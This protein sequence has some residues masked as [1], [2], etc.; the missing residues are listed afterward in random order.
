MILKQVIPIILTNSQ[1]SATPAPFQHMFTY[2]VASNSLINS[3]CS[4]VRFHD[5]NGNVITSWLED[6]SGTWWLLFVNGISANSQII[7][8]MHIYD[9]SNFVFD[10]SSVGEA[11][12]LSATYGQYDNGANVFSLYFNGN[13]PLSDFNNE[14]NGLAQANVMGPTGAKINVISI[15][16]YASNLGFVYTAKSLS[17]SAIIAESSSQ[18]NGLGAGAYNAA[19]GQVAIVSGTDVS[20]L[21]AIGVVMGWSSSYLVN[22]YFS[23]GSM[24]GDINQQG[25]ANAD[26]H[27]ASVTYSGS[28]ATSWTGYIAPQLY[29]TSGGFSGSVSNNPL[30]SSALYLG[31]IGGVNSA[32]AWQTYINWMRARAYPPN[33]VMPFQSYGN[34][35]FD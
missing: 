26:W 7:I 22:E 4:N 23:G 27:Y 8:Y 14:G 13:T 1:S 30:S 9:S 25:T 2:P 29:S 20:V 31:L 5:I 11:P 15:T 34:I 3:D 16:S 21:N 12:Q 18:Q 6:T 10:G 28:A 19:N 35:L 17:N 33:G 24:T 32:D